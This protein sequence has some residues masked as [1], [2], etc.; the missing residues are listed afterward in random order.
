MPTS[1]RASTGSAEA[2]TMAG[3]D[4][5][6][7]M[8]ATP[9][10]VTTTASGWA[11]RHNSAW[12]PRRRAPISASTTSTPSGAPSSVMGSPISLLN[13]PGLAWVRNPVDR[14]EAARSFVEVFPFAPVIPITV[15][16]RMR[17]RSSAANASSARPESATTTT[18]SAATGRCTTAPT[19]PRESASVTKSWPS[20]RSPR[21]AK[22]SEPGLASRLSMTTAVTVA[23]APRRRPSTARATSESGR[24]LMQSPG[25]L[26][27]PRPRRPGRRTAP[28]GRRTP[29]PSRVLSRR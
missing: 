29:G 21:M 7:S 23:S 9:T 3:H 6:T 14:M 13:D 22:N 4:P 19:A 18:G 5:K 15:A 12:S 10:F 27:A 11:T 1:G 20:S 28:C 8:C 24:G 2:S 26:G 16:S 25:A 17:A